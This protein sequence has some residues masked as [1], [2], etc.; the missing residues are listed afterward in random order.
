MI[1]TR[2]MTL[3]AIIGSVV[4]EI[5]SLSF[6]DCRLTYGNIKMARKGGGRKVVRAIKDYL[7]RVIV[8]GG[9]TRSC[10]PN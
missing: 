3:P 1:Y 6:H 5:I 8:Y 9:N 7:G 10:M 4:P 2:I